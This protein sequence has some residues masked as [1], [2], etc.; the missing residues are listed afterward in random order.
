MNRCMSMYADTVFVNGAVVTV[1]RN[2]TVCQAVAV[3]DKYIV[4]TGDNEGAKLWTG[5]ETRV[6]DL[7]GRALLPGFVDAHCHLGMFGNALG[8]EADDGK[9]STRYTVNTEDNQRRSAEA[10]K[11]RMDKSHGLRSGQAQRG[12]A[13]YKSRA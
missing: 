13:S 2:N 4:Y 5:P 9:E 3:R 7:N 1:D 8:F 10:S 12:Q 11:R 6:I